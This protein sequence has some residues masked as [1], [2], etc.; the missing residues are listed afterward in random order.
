FLHSHSYTGNPLACRAALA[1]LDLFEETDALAA[2]M[3]LAAAIDAACA[4]IAAHPRVRH[5]RRLGMIWA[6]DV[7]TTLPDFAR[8]LHRHAMARGLLLRPI[9]NTLYAMPP[10]VLGEAEVQHLATQAMAA[11]QAT[12]AE[13]DTADGALQERLP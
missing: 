2:N 3:R 4:P 5:A 1:T 11:L 13:E 7:D 12:L 8:R 10:Y 6:W 9:G